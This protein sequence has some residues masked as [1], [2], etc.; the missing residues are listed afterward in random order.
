MRVSSAGRMAWSRTDFWQS[1]ARTYTLSGVARWKFLAVRVPALHS[2]HRALARLEAGQPRAGDRAGDQ[3]RHRPGWPDEFEDGRRPRGRTR[4]GEESAPRPRL[5]R[6]ES[7]QP[8]TER[9]PCADPRRYRAGGEKPAQ[10]P[11]GLRLSLSR[12][13]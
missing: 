7:V 6:D 11:H 3:V 8:G 10:Q 2:D 4:F 9:R 13:S 5:R 12:R 1:V